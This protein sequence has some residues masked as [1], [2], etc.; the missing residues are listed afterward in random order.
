MYFKS[1][2]ITYFQTGAGVYEPP[3]LG[4]SF[5]HPPQSGY[6]CRFQQLRQLLLHK[7]HK[8]Y[9]QSLRVGNQR[10]LITNNLPYMGRPLPSR[11]VFL[12]LFQAEDHLTQL[13]NTHGP[14]NSK[15]PPATHLN[16][17]NESIRLLT[18]LLLSPLF[19]LKRKVMLFG[20]CESLRQSHEQVDSFWVIY[21]Q[22]PRQ[23]SW[24]HDK[25]F[26][27]D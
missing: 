8:T 22:G 13:A 7:V 6:R 2:I 27:L 18:H 23:E 5:W 11:S 21:R 14:P 9:S 19:I 26:D 4:C 10:G 20:K 17:I 15:L 25:N 12:K 3:F 1:V 24:G 16:I